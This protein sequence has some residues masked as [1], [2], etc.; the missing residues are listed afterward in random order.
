[1]LEFPVDPPFKL[2]VLSVNYIS[3]ISCGLRALLTVTLSKHSGSG[4]MFLSTLVSKDHIFESKGSFC[5]LL[6]MITKQATESNYFC[7]SV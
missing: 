1:M 3:L 6:S 7:I 4:K 2:V 5:H